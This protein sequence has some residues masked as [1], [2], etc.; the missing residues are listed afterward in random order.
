[1]DKLRHPVF[2]ETI[3]RYFIIKMK[4]TLNINSFMVSTLNVMELWRFYASPLGLAVGTAIT[5]RI[6]SMW[7]AC[8]N[9]SMLGLGYTLPYL[10]PYLNRNMTVF[11]A[12]HASQGAAYWPADTTNRTTLVEEGRLPFPDGGMNR[13]IITHL[14]EIS[15]HRRNVLDEAW[16]LLVPGGRILVVV[17]HRRSIWSRSMASPFGHGQPFTTGQLRQQLEKSGFTPLRTQ[18]ALVMPPTHWPPLLRLYRLMEILGEALCPMFGGVII[19]E[20]E[21]QIYATRMQ[22]IV[23]EKSRSIVLVP[24]APQGA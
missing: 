8:A 1:M 9:E 14:L 11:A 20:A 7:P 18:A 10:Y 19:M 22:T 13:I 23:S 21:K 6:V 16:R 3:K 5:R 15:D 12:M 4:N 24:N 2:Y 17:P